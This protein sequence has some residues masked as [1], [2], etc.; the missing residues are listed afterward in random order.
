MVKKVKQKVSTNPY[1]VLRQLAGATHIEVQ[2][3]LP[4]IKAWLAADDDPTLVHM[5]SVAIAL[6]TYALNGQLFVTG[7]KTYSH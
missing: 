5:D 2:Y 3:F 4:Y 6:L 1:D 7:D